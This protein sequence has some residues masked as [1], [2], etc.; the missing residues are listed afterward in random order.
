MSDINN[1]IKLDLGSNTLNSNNSKLDNNLDKPTEFLS[2]L[3]IFDISKVFTTFDKEKRILIIPIGFPQ[4][5]KSL[6]LSSLM[7]YARKGN[8][9]MFRTN[10]ERD[11]PYDKGNLAVNDMV[12]FFDKGKLYDATQKGTLDLIGINLTPSKAKL[13]ELKLAFLDLAGEDIKSIKTSEKGEFTDKINAVF[14]GLKI[15]NS[16]VIFTLITPYEPAK[17]TNESQQN[18]HDREDALHYDFLN[19]IKQNQPQILKNAKFF[20]IVSQWDRNPNEKD[21]VENYI[22]TNRPSIYNYVK[23]SNVIWGNYSVG[24]LLESNVNGVNMQEIVR[25]NYDYPSRFWKKL[26]HICTNKTLDNK[27]W[28]NKLFG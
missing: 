25:I 19:Y 18:A 1:E 11:F 22:K 9:T 3:S 10:V 6:L 21:N 13:P 8:D 14:N 28:F 7:Y 16:P 27:S 23:N 5:G 12:E 2:D 4:A 15:D 26:Y 20:V 17:L 24:K